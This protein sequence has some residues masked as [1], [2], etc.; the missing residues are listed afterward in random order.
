MS[1]RF[2]TGLGA[3]WN[4]LNVEGGSSVAVFG[5]GAVGL[6]VI[7]GAKGEEGWRC[8]AGG[9]WRIIPGLVSG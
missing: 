3:A 7:Q 9:A 8:I 6:S 1:D 2:R 5:L 4:T